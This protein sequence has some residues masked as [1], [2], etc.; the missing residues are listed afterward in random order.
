MFVLTDND[1]EDYNVIG[2]FTTIKKAQ[3][4]V[5][6]VMQRK[7]L[8]WSEPN[9]KNSIWTLTDAGSLYIHAVVLDPIT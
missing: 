2:V 1:D 4:Y 9:L 7:Y 3:N 5:E 8:K 6:T